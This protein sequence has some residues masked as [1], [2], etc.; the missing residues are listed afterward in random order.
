MRIL[1]VSLRDF[2]GVGAAE[3][4]FASEGVTIVEG[5]NE[6][7][8]TT[9]IN[10]VDMLFKDRSS[11]SKA[12]VRAVQPAGRDVGPWAEIEFETGD[13]HLTYAK[14]WVKDASTELRIHAPAPEQLTGREAENRV[15]QILDETLDVALFDALRQ[16]QGKPLTQAN[17]DKKASLA[18]ALDAAAGVRAAA[19]DDAE[20]L[21]DRIDDARLEWTTPGGQ[22]NRERIKL[23]E[24]AEAARGEEQ[25]AREVL[26]HQEGR[27]DEHRRLA[28][29]IAA[30]DEAEPGLCERRDALAA[31]LAT[32]ERQAERVAELARAA[33]AADDRARAAAAACD[34][35]AALVAAVT[36]GEQRV[37]DAEQRA[38]ALRDRLAVAVAGAA[39][40]ATA[41]SAAGDD[42]READ[43]ALDRAVELAQAIDDVAALEL[44]EERRERVSRAEDDIR[45]A[46]E[47]LASCAIDADLMQRIEQAVLDLA[48]ARERARA[49]GARLVVR[50][51]R[52]LEV[53]HGDA[54]RPV[55]AGDEAVVEV[56]AGDHMGIAGVAHIGV[57]G[58][59]D[60]AMNDQR[61]AEGHLAD[62]LAR[63]GLTPGSDANAARALERSRLDADARLAAARESRRRE[64]RDLT[65]EELDGKI[66][67]AQARAAA[68]AGG[69]TTN[70]SLDA[71]RAAAT[72]A[73][74]ARDEARRAEDAARSEHAAAEE[75]VTEL[76]AN[77][78]GAEAA[79]A[80]EASRL[81]DDRRVL[82]RARKGVPD[83]ALAS[84]A[85]ETAA[86]ARRARAQ[87]AAQKAR[88]QR[89]NLVGLRDRTQNARKAVDRAARDR[90]ALAL[91]AERLLGEIG[92]AGEEGL[93]DRLERATRAAVEAAEDLAK[94]E[95]EAA[96]AELLHE[97]M[98]RHRGAARRAYVAPFRAELEGLARL[99]FGGDT[100]VEVDHATLQVTA[101]TRHGVTVPFDALSGGARE[102]IAL[103]GRLAAARLVSGDGGAP[104][105]IDDALGYSDAA[106][107]EGLGAA[108]AS[109][110]S[111][112]QVIVLTCAPGRYRA[113]GDAVTRRIE[114]AAAGAAQGVR[115]GLAQTDVAQEN[116]TA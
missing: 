96:E 6:A 49:T 82:A 68:H 75:A 66:G 50:A 53:R 24:A 92:Q 100:T 2:R 115:G 4:E 61:S 70:M 64:L 27:I 99:V 111:L 105:I 91:Q 33:D 18:R 73:S 85:E 107:L 74:D 10:A 20:P 30:A 1:R 67:R 110:G 102:Q 11:S 87:H 43:R 35:R 101:R 83:K 84:R 7:G 34:Q 57:E 25:I 28:R 114:P 72:S 32:V 62:L 109:A 48:V 12:S 97:V 56:P 106:R 26:E 19:A 94:A 93:A 80:G 113:V 71:A 59:G 45:H 39:S 103:L 95:R 17:F 78:A 37:A 79:L 36:D 42:A 55:A 86:A 9:L 40:T 51:E 15:D 65:P 46:E 8:K 112:G 44:L 90:S 3:V 5:P 98:T 52:D 21:M 47:F 104:V 13:Y 108:L 23:R 63:A 22:P 60:A 81:D 58:D 77:L 41:L 69:A 116:Y 38:T 76:R 54:V 29:E 89:G 14:R 16:Q 31:E 88:L